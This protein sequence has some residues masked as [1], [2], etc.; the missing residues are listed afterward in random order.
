ML[1]NIS[2]ILNKTP[3]RAAVEIIA[4][5]LSAALLTLS[6]IA[7]CIKK[8]ELTKAEA[9]KDHTKTPLSLET[10]SAYLNCIGSTI[11][12]ALQLVAMKNILSPPS[13]LKN[14]DIV[15]NKIITLVARLFFFMASSVI[16]LSVLIRVE[17]K[18]A[19]RIKSEDKKEL[20]RNISISAI[21]FCTTI[22]GLI[23]TIVELLFTRANIKFNPHTAI[24][25]SLLF[26][27]ASGIASI[28][29]TCY[30]ILS[31]SKQLTK[32]QIE[33]IHTITSA[34]EPSF[35]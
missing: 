20:K 14:N 9:K 28:S 6:I 24:N 35:N 27:I 23:G 8:N 4:T 34:S 31:I 5:F 11:S 33:N 15:T 25:I 30:S 21:V 3:N 12:F 29:I 19:D 18:I 26:Y 1:I 7:A 17:Q 32:T 16:L 10:K 2:K 22:T 13:F